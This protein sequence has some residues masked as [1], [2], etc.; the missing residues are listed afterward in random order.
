M[1]LAALAMVFERLRVI[2][3]MRSSKDSLSS[4]TVYQLTN[5]H[6]RDDTLKAYRSARQ[7]GGPQCLEQEAL[8]YQREISL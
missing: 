5:L 7:Y 3:K 2:G 4:T 8:R 1:I 6:A